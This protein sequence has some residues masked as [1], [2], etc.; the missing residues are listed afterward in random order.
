MT[1]A[2]LSYPLLDEIVTETDPPDKCRVWVGNLAPRVTEFA[3]LK[4]A[5]S[6]GQVTSL[7]L[8]TRRLPYSEG[9]G[10]IGLGYG[11]VSLATPAQA[12]AL[13]AGLQGQLLLGQPLQTRPARPRTDST[14]EEFGR[15]R[16]RAGTNELP[17][18]S[19]LQAGAAVAKPIRRSL[20]IR[21]LEAR[22]RQLED[23]SAR[24]VGPPAAVMS[25]LA[26]REPS[27]K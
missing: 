20:Q 14:L 24:C 8:P 1:P 25:L 9:G 22:L 12:A 21:S 2:G 26:K 15:R 11:F 3:L 4:L 13:I 6:F 19:K 5:Q 27:K 17:K 23:G 7:E 18:S 16:R 10:Q